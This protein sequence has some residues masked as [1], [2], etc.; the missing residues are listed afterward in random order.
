MHTWHMLYMCAARYY[1]RF[2][3]LQEANHLSHEKQSSLLLSADK[4]SHKKCIE[5]RD[6]FIT[7]GDTHERCAVCLGRSHAQTPFSGLSNCLHCDSL[8]LK[9][10]CSRLAAFSKGPASNSCN[11][12]LQLPRRRMRWLLGV[13]RA[14]QSLWRAR[15][16]SI[17]LSSHS[18]LAS[19]K[20]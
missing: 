13:M 11:P 3:F 9:V 8:R 4:M 1:I 14:S 18:H 16:R 20:K 2:K 6:R 7:A 10:L 15:W 12:S 17:L 19:F 5:P